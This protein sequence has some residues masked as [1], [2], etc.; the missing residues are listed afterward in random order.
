M[1]RDDPSVK[2]PHAGLVK[3]PE[4]E[5]QVVDWFPRSPNPFAEAI[6]SFVDEVK[7]NE[8]RKSLFYKQVVQA[9]CNLCIH[10]GSAD[11]TLVSATQLSKYITD[12]E[13]QHKEKSGIRKVFAW[14]QPFVEGLNQ[15][16]AAIDVMIQ[17]DPT[18]SAL[19]YG[20]AKLVLQVRNVRVVY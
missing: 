19:I 7:E 2:G 11:Q 18:V 8:D 4:A 5:S 14:A 20:G 6:L 9:A 1:L 3:T 16:T 15:Y 17:A 12:L 10:D 13:V